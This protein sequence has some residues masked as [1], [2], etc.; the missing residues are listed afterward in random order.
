MNKLKT[1][2]LIIITFAS[3]I[4]SFI[5]LTFIST[6][7]FTGCDKESFITILQLVP[8]RIFYMIGIP[9]F[10]MCF[11]S[12]CYLLWKFIKLGAS[13][14]E[15][16]KLRVKRIYHLDDL[17]LNEKLSGLITEDNNVNDC[18]PEKLNKDINKFGGDMKVLGN[19]IWRL[20][21]YIVKLPENIRKLYYYIKSIINKLSIK[22]ID[23]LTMKSIDVRI[24]TN[25]KKSSL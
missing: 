16:F 11:V 12:T 4:L 2:L 19:K 17:D 21:D 8:A 13:K 23:Y 15:A 5:S 22:F 7:V 3:L 24:K 25:K 10:I 6:Y 20:P 9:L 1:F 18:I 14:P